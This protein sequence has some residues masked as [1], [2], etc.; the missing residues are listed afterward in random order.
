[1]KQ[2]TITYIKFV[3]EESEGFND[4]LRE[5]AL[6]DQDAFA[7]RLEEQGEEMLQEENTT[8]EQD[9]YLDLMVDREMLVQVLDNSK[10]F[11]ENQ[12]N[13]KEGQINK[14]IEKDKKNT[15][16]GITDAQHKR[17]RGIVQEIIL[18]CG[19]FRKEIGDEIDVIKGPDD[20]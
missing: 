10:E 12:V 17:N 14:A 2:R 7:Q 15:E 16:D 9:I 5:A 13:A 20:Y 11:I 3:G 4:R 1:M 8:E 19:C 6:K 18:T